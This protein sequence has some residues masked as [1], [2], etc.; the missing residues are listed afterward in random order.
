[1][2]PPAVV[3]FEEGPAFEEVLFLRDENA[4][5]GWAV[6][7]TVEGRSGDPRSRIDEHTQPPPREPGPVETAELD[8]VFQTG[9]PEHWIPYLPRT[10]G[11]RSMELAQGAMHRFEPREGDPPIPPDGLP[12]TPQGRLLNEAG[13][14]VIADA[15]VP[16]EGVRVRRVTVLARRVDGGYERWTARRV[17]VG[18]GEGASGL[19]FDAAIPR[20]PHSSSFSR[21][22]MP[23]AAPGGGVP[24]RRSAGRARHCRRE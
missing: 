14:K 8:Y 2:V 6:E 21:A 23:V 10:T 12:V 17:S 16:R 5:L 7:R 19:G 9:V 3:S 24:P 22:V 4:N 11:Y 13:S 1:M 18:K 20:R 15:E